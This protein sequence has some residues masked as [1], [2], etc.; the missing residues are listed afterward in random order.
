MKAV[1]YTRVSTEDQANNGISLDAQVAACTQYAV[2]HNLQVD[3]VIVDTMSGKSIER[4]GFQK[5]LKLI[6]GRKIGH[7]I[8]MKL[9]RLSRN[10]IDTLH[11]LNLLSQKQVELHLADSGRVDSTSADGELMMTLRAGFAQAERRKISERTK[12]ALDR[13]KA[14]GHRVSGKPPYG[15]EFQDGRVVANQSEQQAIHVIKKLHGKGMSVRKIIGALDKKG[16]YNRK[17]KTFSV[18]VIHNI[19]HAA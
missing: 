12:A 13:K 18:S 8:A 6:S 3:E 17:G 10:T 11:L 1:I 2:A 4:P 15:Y 9:D 16:L 19:L 5:L 7:L 14:L